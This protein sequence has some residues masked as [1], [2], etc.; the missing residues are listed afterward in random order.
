MPYSKKTL[1]DILFSVADRHD[2]G[3]LPTSSTT[4]AYWTRII[5]RG[6]A[7]CADRLR[8]SK[9]TSL[10]TA[11]GTIALP[12][13]FLQINDVWTADNVPL[14]KVD[15]D[16]LADQIGLAYWITGN[17]TD[18]FALNT[19]DDATYTVK[20]AFKPTELVNNTDV[21]IIPDPEAVSAY[22]YGMIRRSET[23]P[24]GDADASIQECD[25]RLKEIQSVSSI[26][27]NSINFDFD[28]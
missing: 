12:D 22:T 15:P 28:A 9:S 24:I 8:L 14:I 21:C 2:S 10:T 3:V 16:N 26:N 1:S 23:D 6:I 7:Y 27:S 20:Y 18:G 5:N 4:T 19:V 13:D 17:H 25:A 11:S